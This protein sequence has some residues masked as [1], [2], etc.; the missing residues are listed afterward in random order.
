MIKIPQTHKWL[1]AKTLL[2]LAAIGVKN[3]EK[4]INSLIR[5]VTN[6]FKATVI[7]IP[8]FLNNGVLIA[9]W[10]ILFTTRL[11][12]SVFLLIAVIKKLL[13][14]ISVNTVISRIQYITKH[15][16]SVLNLI[17]ITKKIYLII[18][19]LNANPVIHTT[20]RPLMIA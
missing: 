8:I 17:V 20:L 5:I 3:A 9:P 4:K 10:K 1:I 16:R 11:L 13:L 12:N 6:V 2:L 15:S 7:Q 14:K 18:G 19:V